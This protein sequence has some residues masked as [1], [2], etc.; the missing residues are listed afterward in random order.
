MTKP[1]N[2]VRILDL[3]RLLPGGYATLILSDLGAEVIKIESIDGDPSRD[4]PPFVGTESHHHLTINRNKKSV[5][6]NLKTDEGRQIFYELAASSHCILENF[7]PGVANKLGISFETIKKLNNKIVYCSLSGFGQD[8]PYKDLPAFDLNFTSLSG[9]LGMSQQNKHGNPSIQGLLLGD[10]SASLWTVISIFAGLKEVENTGEAT[11]IDL[12][13]QDGLLSLLTIIAGRYFAD[14]KT[15]SDFTGKSAAWNV[16][17]TKDDQYVSLAAY[18]KY[19]WKGFCDLVNRED[20]IPFDFH[21]IEQ[22]DE[23]ISIIQSIFIQKTRSEWEK[24]FF[25]ANIPFTPVKGIEE[26]EDD[27][28]IKKKN[29]IQSYRTS[30]NQ[31]FKYIT[32]PIYTSTNNQ[33]SAPILGEN[34]RELLLSLGYSESKVT[35]L[36]ETGII[37]GI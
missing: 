15:S 35:H 14:G 19:F 13:M 31:E 5:A 12:A 7:R 29:I 22:R 34:S 27:P 16:Y 6:L 21:N 33:R 1:L 25:N 3:S 36:L 2:G 30:G 23:I 26:L 32:T 17:K 20:L 9:I 8:S 11:Y 28:H 10:T 24:L 18:D 4:I 37:K